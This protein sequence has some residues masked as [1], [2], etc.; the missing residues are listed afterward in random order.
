MRGMVGA[1]LAGWLCLVDGAVAQEPRFDVAAEQCRP[2]R[3]GVIDR[4]W[5]VSAPRSQQRIG[6]T[7]T[8]GL[9]DKHGEAAQRV[10]VRARIVGAATRL[11]SKPVAVVADNFADVE[12]PRDFPPTQPLPPGA[13]TVLWL[14]AE[15]GGFLACDGFV[16]R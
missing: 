1:M 9:R 4:Q 3:K 10:V 13:Y 12:F 7:M 16:V 15:T 11:D 14:L 8:L 6:Q 2:Y 5:Q